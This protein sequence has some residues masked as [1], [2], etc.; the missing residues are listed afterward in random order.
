MMDDQE[1]YSN[2]E[3]VDE[4]LCILQKRLRDLEKKV[5]LLEDNQKYFL[6]A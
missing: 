1:F 3:D 6:T 2:R 5:E 4:A